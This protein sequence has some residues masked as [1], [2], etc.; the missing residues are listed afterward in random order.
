MAEDCEKKAAELGFDI[1][2]QFLTLAFAGIAFIVGLSFNTP[3]SV[4]SL[5]LWLT[6]GVFGISVAFGLMFLM[7]G[8]NLLS[9]S[10]TYDIY[11][12]SLRILAGLQIALV[13]VGVVLLVPI[14]NARP[15]KKSAGNPGSVEV[16]I[17]QRQSVVCTT[18]PAKN[19]VIEVDGG[20]VKITTGKN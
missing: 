7:H 15:I 11:A 12:S 9:V 6:V 3:G 20:K 5:M 8:V 4:S 16:K 19:I 10:K 2:K 18:D 14:L 1:T 17:D 13:L